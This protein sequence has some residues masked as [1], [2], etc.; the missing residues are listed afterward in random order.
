MT[1]PFVETRDANEHLALDL[2]LVYQS[3]DCQTEETLAKR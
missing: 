3:L 1:W 2:H